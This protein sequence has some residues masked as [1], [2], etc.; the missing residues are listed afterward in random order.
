MDTARLLKLADHL[1]S[2]KLGHQVFDFGVVNAMLYKKYPRQ[3]PH[4]CGTHGCAIGELPILFPRSWGWIDGDPVLEKKPVHYTRNLR[5]SLNQRVA[6]FFGIAEEAAELLFVAHRFCAVWNKKPLS[7]NSGRKVVA[8]SLRR[9]VEWR[10]KNPRS[11]KYMA[12][13]PLSGGAWA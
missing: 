12:D 9:F 2:G 8:D 1:E 11:E 3:V 7:R 10:R 13:F 6:G 4:G 5:I